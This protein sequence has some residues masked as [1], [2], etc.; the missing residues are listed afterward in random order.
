MH[1]LFYDMIDYQALPK[2]TC[3]MVTDEDRLDTLTMSL[4]CFLNQ[5]YPNRELLIVTDASASYKSDICDLVKDLPDVRLVFLD[6]KYTLGA[7]RNIG[8]GLSH[9]DIFVQWDDDDFNSPDRLMVQC[10]YL[11]KHPEAKLCF[12]GDQLHYYFPTRQLFWNNWE[13]HSGGWKKHGLIPGTIMAYTKDFIYRYPAS[14]EHAAAGEDSVMTTQICN[15]NSKKVV[16]LKGEGYHHVYS[17]HGKN[18]WDVE[19]HM[20]I[21]RVRGATR[22][23]LLSH[24]QRICRTLDCLQL[25]DIIDVVGV[26]GLAFTYRRQDVN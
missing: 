1:I 16:I 24:R 26:D 11:L 14:G 9:G 12:L 20:E 17:F 8:V 25:D 15:G 2:I 19:H 21:S 22:D 18:V 13:M 5:T 7:L 4:K 23:V 10:S 6:G 3:M